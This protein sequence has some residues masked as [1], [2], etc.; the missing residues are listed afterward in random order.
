MDGYNICGDDKIVFATT[1][2][3]EEVGG[4]VWKDK[5]KKQ[6]WFRGQMNIILK[7]INTA[8]IYLRV[9]IF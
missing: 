5:Q 6:F 2:G 9:L 1:E 7:M 4:G 3:E 8:Y